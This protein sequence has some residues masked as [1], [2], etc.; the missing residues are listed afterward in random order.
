MY[1]NLALLT[2][3]Q[4]NNESISNLERRL[5]S[6]EVTKKLTAALSSVTI[7]FHPVTYLAPE[8]SGYAATLKT[9]SVVLPQHFQGACSHKSLLMVTGKGNF[10]TQNLAAS[11]IHPYS[12]T[13]G[14][15][16]SNKYCT[17]LTEF[18]SETFNCLE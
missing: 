6:T 1:G 4:I 15:M 17:G 12:E 5:T 3:S 13:L 14:M 7:S 16:D 9:C 2:V 10:L 8:P 11:V 18:P